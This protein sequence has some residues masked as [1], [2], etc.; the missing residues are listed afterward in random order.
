MEFT[1]DYLLR[2][3]R[4]YSITPLSKYFYTIFTFLQRGL[5]PGFL[6]LVT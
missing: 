4:A 1:I 3:R 6:V 5:L 2:A